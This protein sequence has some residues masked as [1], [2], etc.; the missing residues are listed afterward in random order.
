MFASIS[1]GRLP[2]TKWRTE[3]DA[4]FAAI[5]CG[6]KLADVKEGDY[7]PAEWKTAGFRMTDEERKHRIA[8]NRRNRKETCL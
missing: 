2:D 1:L 6:G 4:Q 3:R 8:E 7:A 5:L